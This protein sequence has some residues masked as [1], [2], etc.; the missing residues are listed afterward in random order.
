MA[1]KSDSGLSLSFVIYNCEIFPKSLTCKCLLV[2]PHAQIRAVTITVHKEREMNF[3]VQF[4]PRNMHAGS[5]LRPLQA[6]SQ[7]GY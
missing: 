6:L 5:S 4:H 1:L 2:W 7:S 3:T